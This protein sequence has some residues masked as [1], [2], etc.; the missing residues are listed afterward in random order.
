ML[1]YP[2]CR[3]L[4]QRLNAAGANEVLTRSS[5]NFT[6]EHRDPLLDSSGSAQSLRPPGPRFHSWAVIRVDCQP[7][8]WHSIGELVK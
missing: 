2:T 7:R 5:Y 6:S 1:D 4:L 3:G 8:V